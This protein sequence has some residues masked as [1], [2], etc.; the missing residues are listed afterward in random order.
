MDKRVLE[1]MLVDLSGFPANPSSVHWFGQRAKNLLTQARSDVASFLGVLPEEIIFTSGAT[2]S[3]NILIR[4]LGNIGHV[5]TTKIEHSAVFNTVQELEKK[6]LEVTYIPVNRWGAPKPEDIEK[7]IK[8]NTKA[9]IFSLANPETGVK[10]DLEKVNAIALKNGV[11]LFLDAVAWIGKESFQMLSGVH[12]LAISAHKF[13]GPK[14]VGA[15]YLSQNLKI[16][17]H[18]TG[19]AQEHKIRAG[20]E[21]LAGILGMAQALEL[22]KENQNEITKYLEQLKKRLLKGLKQ[23]YPEC[24]QNGD[25]PTLSNTLN[26]SFPGLDGETLLMHLDLEGVA[27]SHG[28][29]CS[30][31]SLEPS[32]VL[33]EMNLDRKRARSSIRLSL[34]RMNT[35]EE[36]DGAVD[37]IGRVLHN[38]KDSYTNS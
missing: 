36:I 26:L 25:G 18:S 29:A 17:A 19:G 38:L 2:E 37:R 10:L 16:K 32:R 24:L 4:S 1:A 33:T 9:L 15:L 34:S 21:N 28:S 14:G 3:L 11:P 12:G 31:G 13:H 20:T 5:V 6:G 8:K 35:L 22:I 30:S 7:S 23:A 27:V